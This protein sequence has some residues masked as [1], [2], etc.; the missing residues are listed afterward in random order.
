MSPYT[1]IK[2]G[3]KGK[4]VKVNR[5]PMPPITNITSFER[6]MI[7][8]ALDEK[9]LVEEIRLDLLLNAFLDTLDV[10]EALMEVEFDQLKFDSV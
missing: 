5:D 4:A 8:Y 2:Y 7:D 1:A 6:R 10:K 3:N 9:M